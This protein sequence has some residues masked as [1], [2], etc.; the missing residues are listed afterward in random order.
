MPWHG[1]ENHSVCKLSASKLVSPD[2]YM[3]ALGCGFKCNTV[4]P[5]LPR[6]RCIVSEAQFKHPKY[7]IP[8]N[9]SGYP[10]ILTAPPTTTPP[11]NCTFAY[12]NPYKLHPAPYYSRGLCYSTKFDTDRKNLAQL[13]AHLE[14]VVPQPEFIKTPFDETGIMRRVVPGL[15]ELI[16]GVP[17][18]FEH[19]NVPPAFIENSPSPLA[20]LET[21]AA[22]H[23]WTS[24]Q[25]FG[26]GPLLKQW[27]HTIEVATFGQDGEKPIWECGLKSNRRSE[28]SYSL[29]FTVEERNV[30]FVGA[31]KQIGTSRFH[32]RRN[33]LL[34]AIDH[35]NTY[36]LNASTHGAE[37]EPWRMLVE[38]NNAVTFG[39]GRLWSNVQLNHST[40]TGSLSDAIGKVQGQIHTDPG[41]WSSSYT[42]FILWVRFKKGM[43]SCIQVNNITFT[44]LTRCQA[45]RRSIHVCPDWSLLSR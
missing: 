19:I 33:I 32:E 40:G 25:E 8:L 41:D 34:T 5:K 22:F 43:L 14:L 29:A 15:I 24:L 28:S 31:V 44:D 3:P 26:D 18:A 37:R 7:N 1:D 17:F 35:I 20:T 11:A 27:L 16:P 45:E 2:A 23:T 6:S 42:V 12:T 39:H 36:V 9:Q 38:I 30:G 13:K 21:R 10:L 4:P